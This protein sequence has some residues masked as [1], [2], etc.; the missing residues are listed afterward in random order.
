M[1]KQTYQLFL[2]GMVVAES[3]VLV[4]VVMTELVVLVVVVVV[5]TVVVCGMFQPGNFQV[6]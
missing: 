4:V 6:L 5:M 3:V 1:N 2:W